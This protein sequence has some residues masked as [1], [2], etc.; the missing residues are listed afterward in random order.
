MIRNITTLKSTKFSSL[1]S[2]PQGAKFQTTRILAVKI[3][4]S[5]YGTADISDNESCEK[6]EELLNNAFREGLFSYT[7]SVY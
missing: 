1:N 5:I 3:A 4:Q 7:I 6:I 2:P